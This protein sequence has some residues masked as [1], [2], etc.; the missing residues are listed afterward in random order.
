M[1][2]NDRIA[3]ISLTTYASKLKKVEISSKWKISSAS[4]ASYETDAAEL[5]S[6]EVSLFNE[7][8]L[9]SPFSV[10]ERLL[11]QRAISL[12]STLAFG[13]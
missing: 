2:Y 4:S 13:T 3:R 5:L 11:E 7:I 8:T 12:Q 1:P 6:S 9:T 10:T